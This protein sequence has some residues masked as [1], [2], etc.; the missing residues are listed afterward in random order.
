LTDGGGA[1]KA[2]VPLFFG[3]GTPLVDVARNCEKVHRQPV[4]VTKE[5]WPQDATMMGL[6][7]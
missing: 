7:M 1:S 3:A 6:Q 5:S 2:T 4:M